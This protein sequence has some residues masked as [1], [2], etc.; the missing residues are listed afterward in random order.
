MVIGHHMF[1]DSMVEEGDMYVNTLYCA[2]T[3]FTQLSLSA[4]LFRIPFLP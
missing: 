1:I 3:A 4:P 2:A